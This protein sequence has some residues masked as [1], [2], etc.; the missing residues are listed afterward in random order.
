MVLENSSPL[1]AWFHESDMCVSYNSYTSIQFPPIPAPSSVSYPPTERLRWGTRLTV[2]SIHSKVLAKQLNQKVD[3]V[4]IKVGCIGGGLDAHNVR[5]V[6]AVGQ[7]SLL[8]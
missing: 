4:D 6:R 8:I 3:K 7:G 1:S 5:V 2:F